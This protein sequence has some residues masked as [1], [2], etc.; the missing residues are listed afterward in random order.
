MAQPCGQLGQ[1][2][3]RQHAAVASVLALAFGLVMGAFAGP[4]FEQSSRVVQ[5]FA[6]D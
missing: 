2:G 4:E 6:E 5:M 1:P 3:G